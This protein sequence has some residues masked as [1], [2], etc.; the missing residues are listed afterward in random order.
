MITTPK[1]Y[2]DL[3][4][5][6]Q[7][8]NKPS[9]AVLLPSDEKIY[10][11]DMNSRKIEAPKYLSVELDHRAETIYFKVGRYYDNIDLA[12]MTCVVQYINAKGEGRVYPVP[13]YDVETYADENM[14]LFPWCI[15]GEAT[16]ASGNVTYSVRFYDIDES[17]TYMRYN[18][19]T[20]PSK[21]EVLHGISS[22]TDIDD[23]NDYLLSFKDQI[24]AQ[25]K[26]VSEYDLYWIDAK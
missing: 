15:D 24:L 26:K 7:D 9:L 10:E 14:M 2:Y 12:N 3:L 18:M 21:S 4:Y 11:I 16:K 5:R 6:I 17:A 19:S 20:L 8:E 25:L 23:S 1:E 13:F 22:K